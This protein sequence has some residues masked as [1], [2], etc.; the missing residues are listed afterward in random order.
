MKKVLWAECL[1]HSRHESVQSKAPVCPKIV[2]GVVSWRFGSS[3]KLTQADIVLVVGGPP[4]ERAGLLAHVV[5]RVR[6]AL[7]VGG[8]EREQLHQLAGVVLVRRAPVVVDPGEPDQH[9]R[10]RR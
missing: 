7:G 1:T 2:F 4:G 6:I 5:L 10:V 9:R 3:L 8:A